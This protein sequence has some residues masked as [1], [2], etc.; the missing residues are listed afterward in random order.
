MDG[1]REKRELC[2]NGMKNLDTNPNAALFPFSSFLFLLTATTHTHA[3]FTQAGKQWTP[4]NMLKQAIGDESLVEVA[5]PR[6][7]PRG[8]H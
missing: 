4:L 2:D 6:V 8:T 3:V 5:K 7:A 1:K